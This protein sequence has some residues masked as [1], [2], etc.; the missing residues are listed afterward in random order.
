MLYKDVKMEE[1]PE[2]EP[3]FDPKNKTDKKIFWTVILVVTVLLILIAGLVV[4][5]Y[6]FFYGG[7]HPASQS[8]ASSAEKLIDLLK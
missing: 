2:N 6:M 5:Y 3:K 7:N 8:I 1:R 4:V